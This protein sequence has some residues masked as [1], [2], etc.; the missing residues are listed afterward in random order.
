MNL[1]I[2]KPSRDCEGAVH[3]R[4]DFKRFFNGVPMGLAL[5]GRTSRSAADLLVSL[6]LTGDDEKPLSPP[7]WTNQ[8]VGPNLR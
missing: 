7:C 3:Y 1:W 6:R 4:A 2:F 5:V 8:L